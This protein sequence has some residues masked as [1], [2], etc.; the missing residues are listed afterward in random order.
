M[1]NGLTFLTVAQACFQ[2]RSNL[3]AICSVE[4]P[5]IST[6]SD[7]PEAEHMMTSTLNLRMTFPR[8]ALTA[9]AMFA[10]LL[11]LPSIG[12]AQGGQTGSWQIEDQETDGRV[13]LRF[14]DYERDGSR[15][16]NSY[17][18]PI[19][20]LEGLSLSQ[21]R[22][23]SSGAHFR[24][25]RDAGTFTFDGRVGSGH[26]AGQFRFAADPKFS[27]QLGARGYGA[28]DAEQSF[29][30]AMFD[31]GFSL[32]DELKAQ[33]YVRP[34]VDDLVTMG[35]HGARYDFVHGLAQLG[36]RLH[37]VTEL[38]DL[39]DHGVTPA[40][41]SGLSTLGYTKLTSDKLLELRDHGVTPSYVS[42]MHNAG[43]RNLRADDLVELRDHGVNSDFVTTMASMGYA[44]LSTDDLLTARDHGVTASFADGFR[45]LGYTSV[46]LSQLVRLR[47]HGVTPEFAAR[48]RQRGGS[49]PSIQEL[50]RL[51]D[52]G[53]QD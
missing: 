23:S 3:P 33:G 37:N 1:T 15:S 39:R 19:A 47:D 20:S 18:V 25:R 22:G 32:I 50:I 38:V 49:A 36:Y 4:T 34:S 10:S 52:G 7:N 5:R 45:K 14:D 17:P 26:G 46:S 44:N 43:Y 6:H 41:I 24:L 35:E 29:Q 31:I 40:F 27:Q 51:R 21:L 9:L 28:P 13:Q 12:H 16:S 8:N 11:I 48:M 2:G 53:D 42:A 30:L